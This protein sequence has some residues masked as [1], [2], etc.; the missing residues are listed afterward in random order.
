MAGRKIGAKAEEEV[1]F[2]ESLLAQA[3]GLQRKIEEYAACKKGCDAISQQITR[4]LGEWRQQAMIKNLGPLADS[5]GMLAVACG[6]G[7]QM[8]RTR[9]MREG[10]ASFKQLLDRV[11][12]ATIDAGEREMKAAEAEKQKA[13]DARERARQQVAREAERQQNPPSGGAQ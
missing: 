13:Q 8:Q 11:I 5:A 9:T 1:T 2:M 10:L 7:S 3:D 12:K 4:K 6:R